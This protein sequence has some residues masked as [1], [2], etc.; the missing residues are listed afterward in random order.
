MILDIWRQKICINRKSGIFIYVCIPK[1]LLIQQGE[2]R[3]SS[4]PAPG[5]SL[6]HPKEASTVAV[7]WLQSSAVTLDFPVLTSD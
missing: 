2:S 1:L 3:H 7:Q 6:W 5:I 4:L